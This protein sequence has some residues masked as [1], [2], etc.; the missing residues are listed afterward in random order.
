MLI[1]FVQISRAHTVDFAPPGRRFRRDKYLV[2]RLQAAGQ[3]TVPPACRLASIPPRS[4]GADLQVYLAPAKFS[5]ASDQ[6]R[7]MYDLSSRSY[8]VACGAWYGTR[9]EKTCCREFP[10]NQ[11]DPLIQRSAQLLGEFVY[12][13]PEIADSRSSS[14]TTH[15]GHTTP[16]SCHQQDAI[17]MV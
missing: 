14:R 16:G 3:H 12:C 15:P 10:R 13:P 2:S 6:C 4:A 8:S 17:D 11:H 1:I 7:K 9:T 5:A